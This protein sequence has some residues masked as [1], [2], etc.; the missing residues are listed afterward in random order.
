[1]AGEWL[2]AIAPD[3]AGKPSSQAWFDGRLRE[4]VLLSRYARI[5]TPPPPS[6]P[7]KHLHLSKCQYCGRTAPQTAVSTGISGRQTGT[8]D[9]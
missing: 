1:M 5:E 9:A 6:S 4:P 7:L 8:G 2:K 3:E